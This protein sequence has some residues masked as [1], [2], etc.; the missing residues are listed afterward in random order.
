MT[1]PCAGRHQLKQ[2]SIMLPLD[3]HVL[4]LSLAFI[5]SQ[6]QTLHD[7]SIFYFEFLVPYSIREASLFNVRLPYFHFQYSQRTQLFLFCLPRYS[8][9]AGAK[10][11]R[12]PPHFQIFCQL[13]SRYFSRKSQS[14]VY[15]TCDN[16]TFFKTS[17]H[18]RPQYDKEIKMTSKLPLFDSRNS[19]KIKPMG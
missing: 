6:D 13:F 4:G 8:G 18:C 1:H 15:H 19:T 2:A 16:P 14:T 9:K 17:S 7:N 12:F 3:L 10:I 5:L 11:K